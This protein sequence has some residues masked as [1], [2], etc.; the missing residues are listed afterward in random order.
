MPPPA[1][2][3]PL[4]AADAEKA[5]ALVGQYHC[6]SCHGPD[7]AGQ[8]TIPRIAGQHADYLRQALTSYKNNTRR[9]YSPAMN[10]ASQDIKDDEIPLLANYVASYKPGSN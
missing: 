3:P 7:L 1:P 2:A 8:Q 6:N 4:A 9:G 5:A 10:E